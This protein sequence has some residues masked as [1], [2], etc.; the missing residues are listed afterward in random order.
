MKLGKGKKKRLLAEVAACYVLTLTEGVDVEA[1]RRAVA[2]ARGLS[3]E[4]LAREVR[5][6]VADV[7]EGGDVA[8]DSREA[9]DEPATAL[10]ALSR[11][12]AALATRLRIPGVEHLGRGSFLAFAHRDQETS[13]C[14]RRADIPQ[15][16]RGDAAAAAWR[17]R[18]EGSRRRRGC[19]VDIP[20][21][22]ARASGT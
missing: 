2:E 12:E 20:R 15:T 11:A 4:D 14:F 3:D 8:L 10:D 13:A 6:V 22:P 5:E 1:A 17:I 7:L 16:G 9:D 18:G 21:R 19:H